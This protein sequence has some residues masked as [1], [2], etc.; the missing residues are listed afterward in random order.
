MQESIDMF[1]RHFTLVVSAV[2][3]VCDGG[4]RHPSWAARSWDVRFGP[5][6]TNELIVGHVSSSTTAWILTSS[7]ALVRVDL[8]HGTSTRSSLHPL[9]ADE[10]AWGLGLAA[11]ELW[12]LIGR[13]TLA[14]VDADG[15]VERR[16]KLEH[17]HVGVFSGGS[18]LLYQV[19]NFQ[20]PADALAAGPPGNDGRRSWGRMRTRAMPLARP[21]VAA[22]NL[23]SCG[24][25]TNGT[26]PCWFPDQAAIT[27]TD[28]MGESRQLALDGLPTVAPE[29]LLASE[30]PQRPIRDAFVSGTGEV[31]ILGSGE[32]PSSDQP[33]RPGGWLLARY[34][35]SGHLMGRM[36]LPEPA[37][38][39]LN[40]WDQRCLLLAWDG[41]VVEVHP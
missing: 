23:V 13:S 10:H 35:P 21:A 3:L 25:T 39:L 41:R 8:E 16:L 34:D 12:T 1:L 6:I 24:A 5:I 29:L 38:L 20:P 36:R 4:C 32:P 14:R 33:V 37:R 30:N 7:D 28:S 2:A 15:T 17:P 27:L 19:M 22:L 31:W 11:D 26:V 9:G 18:E 40:A